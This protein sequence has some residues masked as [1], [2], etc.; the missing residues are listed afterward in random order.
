MVCATVGHGFW[1]MVFAQ[2]V[3][4]VIQGEL[5][6]VCSMLHQHPNY[7]LHLHFQSAASQLCCTSTPTM[8]HL[9]LNYAFLISSVIM[10]HQ[11]YL[12]STPTMLHLHLSS[13]ALSTLLPLL[14]DLVSLELLFKPLAEAAENGDF[15]GY[16]FYSM[17]S[18]RCQICIRIVSIFCSRPYACSQAMCC[19]P[20][21][22]TH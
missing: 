3:R 7:L 20:F 1:L 5:V 11:Q 17:N 10:N 18:P 4:H 2:V 13:A 6:Q 21:R 12:S 9:H 15:G 19:S 14:Q 8:L 22:P 16:K